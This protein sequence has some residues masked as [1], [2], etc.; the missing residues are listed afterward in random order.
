M[1][2]EQRSNEG[3]HLLKY[4]P[5]SDGTYSQNYQDTW[6]AGVARHN[7]WDK[8]KGFFLDLGAFDGLQCSNTALVE[9]QF[10]WNGICVEP[11]PAPGAFDKRSCVLVQSPLGEKSG[12]PVVF[13]GP[14]GSQNK[15]IADGRA[16]DNSVPGEGVTM[17]TLNSADLIH[18]VNSTQNNLK[19]NMKDCGG[20]PRS[21]HVPDFI[22]FVSLDIEYHGLDVLKSFPFDRVKV[23]AW[24]IESEFDAERDQAE[25]NLLLK[26]GYIRAPVKNPGVDKYYIQPR[27]WHDSL[28]EKE[29]RKHPEGSSGC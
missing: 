22:N 10:G 13:V 21:I 16:G 6:I 24:V 8:S 5:G 20:V 25:E 7:G 1:R 4:V 29:F 19:A 3:N 18:C 14:V 2:Q 26:H 15:H 27:F 28:A 11:R 23:G 12:K 9:K 17:Y